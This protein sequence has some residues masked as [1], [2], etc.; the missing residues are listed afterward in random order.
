MKKKMLLLCIVMASGCTLS[1]RYLQPETVVDQPHTLRSG[2][3]YQEYHFKDLFQNDQ[4]LQAMLIKAL[5][6][7]YDLQQARV[8]IQSAKSLKLSALFDLIPQVRA[9]VGHSTGMSSQY[10]LYTGEKIKNKSKFY[11]S[12]LGIDSYEIDIWGRKQAI[13]ESRDAQEKSSL[14]AFDAARLTLL[15]DLASSWYETLSYIKIW[16][17]INDKLLRIDDIHRKMILID[18]IGRLDPLIQ[19][20]FLRGKATDENTRRK[21]ENEII[22]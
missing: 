19:A 14:I 5:K 4:H 15:N 10:S 11:Q 20:K 8:R 3:L 12:S 21:I 9:S 17:L 18:K 13:I 16:H 6:N 2:K 7:N 1:P 22:I